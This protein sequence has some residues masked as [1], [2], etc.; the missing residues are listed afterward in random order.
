M[1]TGHP[2]TEEQIL[3]IREN[4]SGMRNQDIADALGI[5]KATVSTVQ[6]RF[7][8]QKSPEQRRKML[9]HAGKASAA[10]RDNRPLNIT[11]EVIAKR[12]E[13]Y[14]RTFREEQVR[15]RWGVHQLTKIKVLKQPRQKCSQRSYLKKLGYILD[16][17]NCIAYYTED[18]TRAVRMESDWSMKVHQYYKFKPYE[19]DQHQREPGL[20]AVAGE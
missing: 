20:L 6:R 8:L 4:F 7:H 2:L 3:F 12:V 19:Q 10:A 5:S 18:T 16:E 14:K 9:A 17:Q 1:S 11:P 15:R 13:S